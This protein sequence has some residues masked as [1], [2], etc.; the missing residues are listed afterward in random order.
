MTAL[1]TEPSGAPP[2]LRITRKARLNCSSSQNTTSVSASTSPASRSLRSQPPA[3]ARRG[4]SRPPG[5]S[6]PQPRAK[7]GGESRF[8]EFAGSDGE[9]GLRRFQLGWPPGAARSKP[10]TGQPPGMRLACC[11]RR[12]HGSSREPRRSS[13]PALRHRARHRPRDSEVAPMPS[14]SRPSSRRPAAPPCSTR[15][16]AVKQQQRLFRRSSASS[17]REL[18][19]RCRGYSRMNSRPSSRLRLQRRVIRR[20]HR[21]RSARR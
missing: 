5:S 16:L 1:R 19:D 21:A 18:M 7:P 15:S 4:P 6:P 2:A 13:R 8:V 20:D 9:H 3:Q 14:R 12:K 10:R 17:L 11:H